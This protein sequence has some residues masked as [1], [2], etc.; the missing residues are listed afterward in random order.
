MP[1]AP[2]AGSDVLW[3]ADWPWLRLVAAC[4]GGEL[5]GR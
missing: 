5:F 3:L 1:A 2:D 4:H